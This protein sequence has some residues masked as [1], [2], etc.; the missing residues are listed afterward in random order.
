MQEAMVWLAAAVERYSAHAQLGCERDSLS[1]LLFLSCTRMSI[2]ERGEV[3]LLCG[4]GE[5]LKAR[6]QRQIL[7][8]TADYC[9]ASRAIVVWQE[10]RGRHVMDPRGRNMAR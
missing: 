2:N 5:V 10:R 4:Q 8:C 7:S 9:D 1:S 6:I 3:I